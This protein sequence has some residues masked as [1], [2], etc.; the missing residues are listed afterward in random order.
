MLT[1][2]APRERKGARLKMSLPFP[3][4]MSQTC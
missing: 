2:G 1:N 3:V 4:K